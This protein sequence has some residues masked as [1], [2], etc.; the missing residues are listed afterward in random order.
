LLTYGLV[1][2]S[3]LALLAAALLSVAMI[4]VVAVRAG[5]R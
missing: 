1:W 2:R 3:E 5:R 4:I